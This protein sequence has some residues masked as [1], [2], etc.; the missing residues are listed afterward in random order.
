MEKEEETS[1]VFNP[2][3]PTAVKKE[4][5]LFFRRTILLLFPSLS[6]SDHHYHLSLA[7]PGR[8]QPLCS[9]Y[10][11]RPSNKNRAPILPSLQS[12]PAHFF[13]FWVAWLAGSVG[14]YGSKK[15]DPY[16]YTTLPSPSP[17]DGTAVFFPSFPPFFGFGVWGGGSVSFPFGFGVE[18][19]RRPSASLPLS[20]LERAKKGSWIQDRLAKINGQKMAVV[21]R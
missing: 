11:R 9:N 17:D 15:G 14:K 20:W 4:D 19:R 12:P 18:G 5:L 13:C 10:H 2:H 1:R 21:L 6:S 8:G 16:T 3:L 7:S